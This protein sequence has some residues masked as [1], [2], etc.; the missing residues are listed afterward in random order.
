MTRKGPDHEWQMCHTQ[1]SNLN[2]LWFEFMKNR[3]VWLHG[4][5]YQLP[6]PFRVGVGRR[7]PVTPT[8][9]IDDAFH[10]S[11][12]EHNTRV[13]TICPAKQ[14]VTS[15]DDRAPHKCK[16]CGFIFRSTTLGCNAPTFVICGG[17]YFTVLEIQQFKQ[18]TGISAMYVGI[19]L[20]LILV[21]IHN[22]NTSKLFQ[23][24]EKV[25]TLEAVGLISDSF[26]CL[27]LCLYNQLIILA[28]WSEFKVY[29]DILRSFILLFQNDSAC[30][31]ARHIVWFF[32]EKLNSLQW[33]ETNIIHSC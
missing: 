3:S 20:K 11:V 24:L 26:L 5:D 7:R 33:S 19:I 32:N 29:R 14:I 8:Q 18:T 12:N 31:I 30:C 27:L 17:L 25:V 6:W 16:S 21:Q 23:V 22:L 15:A 9:R 2:M 10:V 1:P 13:Q 28:Y 4:M